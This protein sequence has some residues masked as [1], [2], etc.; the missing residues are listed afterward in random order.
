MKRF[1]KL[2]GCILLLV[3]AVSAQEQSGAIK[4][5]NGLLIVWNE[6]GN[7][8]TIEIK[9]KTV[10]PIP[11]QTLW[12]KVD[13]K[14][15]QIATPKKD[16]FAKDVKED[17]AVLLA[18]MKWEADYIGGLLK[19]EIKPTSTWIKL[20]NGT[21]ANFW[22]FDMPKIAEGQTARKQLYISVVKGDRVLMVNSP[23]EGTEDEKTI[24]KLLT[25]H[26]STLKPSDKPL[27]LQKASEMVK[28]GN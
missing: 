18:Q 10:E 2:L 26:I 11:N 25:D 23:V 22:S 9:G 13:G 24:L 5:T 27:S 16:Q 7:Y 4:T 3:A 21:E 17:R 20:S 15:F 8:Y 1:P 14:F 19:Q 28:A 12:F 6:P